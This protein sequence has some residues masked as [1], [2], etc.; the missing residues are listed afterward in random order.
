MSANTPPDPYFNNIDFNPS[1]FVAPTDGGGISVD[2]ANSHYLQSG[3]NV[4]AI[5][6]ANSTI[7]NNKVNPQFF[8]LRWLMLMMA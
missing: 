7:F 1:F 4:N 5:S 8:A 3:A 2:Y 6:T